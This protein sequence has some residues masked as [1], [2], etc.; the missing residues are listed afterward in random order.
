MYNQR[1]EV[2]QLLQQ[3]ESE[4]EAASR[5]VSGLASVARHEYIRARMEQIDGYHKTLQRVVSEQEAIRLIAETL[6]FK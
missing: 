3:I 4:Y 2:A 1:S 6:V 5:G